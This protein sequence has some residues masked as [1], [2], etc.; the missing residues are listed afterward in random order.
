MSGFKFCLIAVEHVLDETLHIPQAVVEQPAL[1]AHFYVALEV[2]EE[3]ALVTLWGFLRFDELIKYRDRNNCQPQDGYYQLPLALM[4]AEPNHLLFYC[5]S[6]QPAAIALKPS[7]SQTHR[8]QSFPLPISDT[9]PTTDLFLGAL[10]NGR[11]KLTQWLQGT[12]DQNWRTI[13]QLIN[14]EAYLSLS[15]RSFD[16]VARRGKLI[17]L[18]LQFGQQTLAL[19]VNVSAE[20]EGKL[21]VL[22]QLHPT[23]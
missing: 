15:P 20:A 2:S 8:T 23:G 4:D 17:H 5:R 22:V 10:N 6:L 7:V 3:Q 9:T 12:F 18:G 19:L 14:P 1:A 21:G 13:D 16:S 11:T